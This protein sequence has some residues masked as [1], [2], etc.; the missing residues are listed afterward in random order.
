MLGSKFII[1]VPPD[2]RFRDINSLSLGMMYRTAKDR[3]DFIGG[4][5]QWDFN[6]KLQEKGYMLSSVPHK[7]C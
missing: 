6:R 4:T 2:V 1:L 5:N 3:N 7:T